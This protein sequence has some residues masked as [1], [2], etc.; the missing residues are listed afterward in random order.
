MTH[1]PIPTPSARLRRCLLSIPAS[2]AKMM[3]KGVTTAADAVFFDLE[4]SVA[5]N[6]KAEARTLAVE[7]LKAHDWKGAGKSVSIR[8]NA[9]DTVWTYQ[10]II[11]VIEGAGEHIDTI[12]L[13]K[14]GRRE[15]I[16]AV[17]ALITQLC[18]A[19]GQKNLITIEGLIESASGV[20]NLADITGYNQFIGSLRLEALHFG[21]GDYAASVRS[22][23]TSIGGAVPD[24]PGD[25][26]HY[27]LAAMVATCHAHG[28]VPMDSAFGDFNDPDGYL[29]VAKRA[30]ALGMAGKWAI[31]P[32]Q[33]ALANDVFT[34]SNDVITRAEDMIKALEES[35][36]SGAGAALYQGQMIDAA[37]TR[38]ARN[39][40]D[41]AKTLGMR[42]S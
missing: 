21:A 31:H 33:I 22:P 35:E 24:Y 41:M 28:V 15:D 1:R 11:A 9:L 3:A 20:V 7:A 32:S 27:P 16:Y 40:V 38:M 18:R 36:A 8:V 29:V 37:S 2:S 10:D 6:A 19:R 25:I 26:W 30:R 13:P 39:I 17:D 23:T 4:D 34:P 12:I 42:P 14:V 5:P